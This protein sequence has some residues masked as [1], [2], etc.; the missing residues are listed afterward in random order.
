MARAR[1]ESLLRRVRSNLDR[2]NVDTVGNAWVDAVLVIWLRN[3]FAWACA[4]NEMIGLHLLRINGQI[5]RLKDCRRLDIP[6]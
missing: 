1:S 3:L 6:I 5:K 4:E 2:T